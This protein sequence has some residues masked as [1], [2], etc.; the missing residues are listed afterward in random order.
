[1]GFVADNLAEGGAEPIRSV[2]VVGLVGF[3]REACTNSLTRDFELAALAYRRPNDSSAGP[4]S[5]DRAAS[6][7]FVHVL[8]CL[9]I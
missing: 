3:R 6:I 2:S 9:Y 4:L 7:S 1:M 5:T 8:K